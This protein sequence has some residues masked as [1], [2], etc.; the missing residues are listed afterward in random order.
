MKTVKKIKIVV[1]KKNKETFDFWLRRCKTLYNVCLDEKKFFYQAT[2]ESLNKYEQKK[3]LV[4]LKKYDKSWKDIPNKSLQEIVFRVD[5]SF[6]NF[7]RGRGYPKYKNN[8]NFNSITFMKQDVRIKNNLA[9][10]PKIKEGIK[11]FE[12]FPEDY[13]SVQLLKENE[14]YYLIFTYEDNKLIENKILNKDVVGCDLGLKTLMT[15]SNGL[16]IKRFSISL[17]K[18]YE[19]RIKELNKSLAT[20]KRGSKRRKKVKRQLKKTYQKLSNSRKDYLH[21]ESTKYIKNTQEDIVA[22]GDLEVKKLMK[23]DNTKQQNNFSRTY[24]NA[25]I[26]IFVDMLN[27]KSLK[28]GKHF[29]K[30]NEEYTSKTC[31]CCSK[32]NKDLKVSD[33]N[34]NC[35]SCNLSIPRDVNGAINI[36]KVYLGTF[37]PIGVK[38]K[39]KK[40]D[41]NQTEQIARFEQSDNDSSIPKE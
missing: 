5:K 27:Y 36:M 39:T 2:G 25:G 16:E 12:K 10:L 15:D 8:D 26:R 21:K 3:E 34:F 6:Q 17:V 23:S 11:G 4:D 24:S 41:E 29:Y 35:D 9:H 19:N 7:F 40:S 1:S 33:R 22:I 30:V 38:L 18:K 13:S 28:Y 14:N 37:N 20:K 31:S 32:V